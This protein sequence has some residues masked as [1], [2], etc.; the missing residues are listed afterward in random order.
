MLQHWTSSA[1]IYRRPTPNNLTATLARP[2]LRK[3]QSPF[4]VNA[5]AH[6]RPERSG[7]PSWYCRTPGRHSGFASVADYEPGLRFT[8]SD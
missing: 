8:E 3:S 2:S 7:V 1:L 5:D 6:I 4:V